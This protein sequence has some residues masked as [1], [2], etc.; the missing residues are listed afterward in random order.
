M[1]KLTTQQEQAVLMADVDVGTPL[2]ISAFA[3][4]GKTSTLL[5]IANNKPRGTGLYI[6]FGKAIADEAAGK[7][8]PSVDCRTAHSLAY[9]AVGFRYKGDRL[10]GRLTKS[11]VDKVLGLSPSAPPLTWRL[12]T[13]AVKKFCAS[14]DDLIDEQHIDKELLS[15]ILGLD[16]IP[17]SVGVD[18][19]DEEIAAAV[20][21]RDQERAGKLAGGVRRSIAIARELFNAQMDVNSDVPM[22][23]DF[24][25]KLWQLSKPVLPYDYIMFDEAQDADALMLDIVNRQVHAKRI[26]VGDTNQ[27]IFSWR[28]AVNAM[29]KIV[30]ADE[31]FISKS[32]RFGDVIADLSNK[33]LFTYPSTIGYGAKVVFDD[34][35]YELVSGHGVIKSVIGE[36]N[37]PNAIICRSNFGIIN[38]VLSYN[39]TA[40]IFVQG[41]VKEITIK[42]RAASDLISKG[43]SN[44][45]DFIM[46]DSWDA[47]VELSE[48]DDGSEYK[49]LVGLVKRFNYDLSPVIRKLNA[50]A[51]VHTQAE[52]VV[53]TAHKAKGLEWDYVR[54]GSDF[55]V[56]EYDD[57]ISSSKGVINK[58]E[59]NILYVAVT[60][61]KLGLDISN[62]KALRYVLSPELKPV[63]D[64]D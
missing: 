18:A 44:H 29:D 7:F 39:N 24:Y 30:G 16:K 9:R 6:A 35:D 12:A 56:L 4:T 34:G 3:G 28:G 19:D 54:L 37:K 43:S 53:T 8:P 26:F 25:F 10:S 48:S 50:T 33:V 40:M 38:E 63:D 49:Q 2:K 15:K 20:V 21:K 1:N 27:Q 41:G 59:R 45:Q 57:S 11:I 55:R 23:H 58:E 51:K 17:L 5:A 60:R 32:F 14:V 31:V 62:C 64:N 46:F 42:L 61:A 52:V 13:T 36:F 47:V 22:T